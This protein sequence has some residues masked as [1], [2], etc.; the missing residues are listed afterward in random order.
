MSRG[1]TLCYD[2]RALS[3][4]SRMV[5]MALHLTARVCNNCCTRCPG[6]SDEPPLDKPLLR[7]RFD[8]VN[9]CFP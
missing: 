2:R 1:L 4:R 3:T 5:Q 7:D 8:Q 6:W 9:N